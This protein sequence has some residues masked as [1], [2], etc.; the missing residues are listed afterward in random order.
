MIGKR[1]PHLRFGIIVASLAFLADQIS[2]W[3]VIV[4]LSLEP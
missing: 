1:S 4:P 3:I 2:K